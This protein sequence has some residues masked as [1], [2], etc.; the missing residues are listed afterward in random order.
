M[1][2]Q[3]HPVNKASFAEL[4]HSENFPLHHASDG[5]VAKSLEGC[6]AKPGDPHPRQVLR[7][8]HVLEPYLGVPLVPVKERTR[9][10]VNRN[11]TKSL[12][13]E[14]RWKTCLEID[15]VDIPEIRANP[16][17]LS[18]FAARRCTVCGHSAGPDRIQ[19]T[20]VR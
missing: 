16:A 8:Q 10:P 12:A 14:D 1:R 4:P 9:I 15:L 3:R 2:A 13:P 7:K 19:L 6:T 20:N 18:K 11:G 17:E 5:D